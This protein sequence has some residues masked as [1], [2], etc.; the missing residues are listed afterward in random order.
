MSERCGCCGWPKID[1]DFTGRHVTTIECPGCGFRRPTYTSDEG[2]SG[3][4]PPPG[5]RPEP[6]EGET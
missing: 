5:V 6:E 3:F 1:A 2:T 4:L